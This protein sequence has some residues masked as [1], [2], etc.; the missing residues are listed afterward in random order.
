MAE[1]IEFECKACG[2]SFQRDKGWSGKC[3][4]CSENKIAKKRYN[5]AERLLKES[6]GYE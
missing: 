3:P 2:Y 5:D 1:R 6:S 4:Y